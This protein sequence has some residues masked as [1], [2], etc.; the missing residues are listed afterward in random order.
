MCIYIYICKYIYICICICIPLHRPPCNSAL[1][2]VPCYSRDNTVQSLLCARCPS[3]AGPRM[4]PT[5]YTHV[6]HH[7]IQTSQ[8]AG[9]GGK[10]KCGVCHDVWTDLCEDT[11]W[12]GHAS[13]SDA[14]RPYVLSTKPAARA[15]TVRC[16]LKLGMRCDGLVHALCRVQTTRGGVGIHVTIH[17]PCI[18][19]TVDIERHGRG[20]SLMLL[21]GTNIA[22]DQVSDPTTAASTSHQ[23]AQTRHAAVHASGSICSLQAAGA[24][25]AGP[26]QG[27]WC[28]HA[29]G[30][31]CC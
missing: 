16:V 7:L 3:A 1:L 14:P 25:G 20:V 13:R 18:I 30:T 21:P 10:K 19:R 9:R 5:S 29:W 2:L 6:L 22:P 28:V 24:S 17:R 8:T 11:V 23:R 26:G 27:A 15:R 4:S 31:K 12:W